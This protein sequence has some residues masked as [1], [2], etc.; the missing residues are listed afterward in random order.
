MLGVASEAAVLE[1]AER[2][3][4][5]L[6]D[7]DKQQFL[8]QM[9]SLKLNMVAKFN[10]FQQKMRSHRDRLPKQVADSLELTVHA[11]AEFLR[12]SRNDAGHPTGVRSTAK[13]VF[14]SCK[15]SFSTRGSFTPSSPDQT[16]LGRCVAPDLR[17][18]PARNHIRTPIH[19]IS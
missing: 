2:L 13:N 18:Q 10:V 17:G 1:A 6:N 14:L 15:C 12:I 5:I 4:A 16:A 9:G 11:V 19:E 8:E 3:A 7:T